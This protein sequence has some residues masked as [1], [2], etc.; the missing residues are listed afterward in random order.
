[1]TIPSDGLFSEAAV[2]SEEINGRN[3]G[4]L[5]SHPREIQE[6]AESAPRR[7]R[8]A[9]MSSNKNFLDLAS[10]IFNRS[11]G[12]GGGGECLHAT[13]FWIRTQV[14]TKSV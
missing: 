1:M 11:R 9:T 3:M 12:N 2:A 8:K 14:D 13:V 4:S 5:S 7:R 6:Q 10:S